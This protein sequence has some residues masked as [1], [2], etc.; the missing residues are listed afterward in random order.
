MC[1]YD[2]LHCRLIVRDLL[3]IYMC[4]SCC[5]VH[6][7]CLFLLCVHVD[8]F[9]LPSDNFSI[10]MCVYNKVPTWISCDIC[11]C[12]FIVVG[13]IYIGGPFQTVYFSFFSFSLIRIPV[14]QKKKN[15]VAVF[16]FIFLF[17]FIVCFSHIFFSYICHTFVMANCVS[18]HTSTLFFST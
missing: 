3:C 17:L 16:F 15:L 9:N 1:A 6:S 10:Y 5:C 14:K 13:V 4:F 18:I 8:V 7:L 11:C 12:C 2:D